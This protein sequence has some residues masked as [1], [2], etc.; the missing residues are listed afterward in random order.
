MQTEAVCLR[1]LSIVRKRQLLVHERRT[2]CRRCVQPA[3]RDRWQR[4]HPLTI[5][6]ALKRVPYQPTSLTSVVGQP[7]TLSRRLSKGRQAEEP[8]L[9]FSR[10]RDS[11]MSRR[12]H[13]CN[14][15]FDSGKNHWLGLISAAIAFDVSRS[16]AR[17]NFITQHVLIRLRIA[18]F[19]PAMPD[20]RDHTSVVFFPCAVIQSRADGEG[21]HNYC[22]DYTM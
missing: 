12:L 18:S 13:P 5:P 22:V 21:P 1:H 11:V 20:P 2:I 17:E 19:R 8:G 16:N 4:F 6:V 14:E 9:Q 3:C 15:L 10:D 7:R